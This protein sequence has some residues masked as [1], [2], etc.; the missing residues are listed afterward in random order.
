MLESRYVLATMLLLAGVVAHEV[1]PT[2]V[3]PTP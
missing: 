3:M 2:S 1:L